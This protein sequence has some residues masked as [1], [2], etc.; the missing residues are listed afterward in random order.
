MASTVT[1][2]SVSASE[3]S[4]L[5]TAGISLDFSS[6]SR[7]AS[8]RAESE[9]KAL[10]MCRGAAV[11]KVVEASPQGLAIDR[12]MTLTSAVRRVVQHGGM[13]TERS[14]DRGGIELPQDATDRRVSG[15]FPPLHPERIA[16]PGK[17]NIDETVDRPIGV[18]TRDDC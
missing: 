6:Q 13:T 9:A 7:C 11:K 4:K 17:V 2:E 18:G 5:W 12:H 15:S 3:P 1:T 8:T 16:Q 10:S 14:F